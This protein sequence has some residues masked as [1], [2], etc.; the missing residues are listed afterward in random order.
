MRWNLRTRAIL[1]V[2]ALAVVF[3]GFSYR[4]IQLQHVEHEKYK[5]IAANTHLRKEPI[6][7]RRGAI[8]DVN[9]ELLAENIPVRHVVVDGSLVNN[10]AELV[11]LLSAELEINSAEIAAKITPERKYIII[12]REVPEEVVRRIRTVA[13]EKNLK[14]LVFEPSS[15]RIYPN[16][17]MLAHVISFMNQERQGV[18]GV[19]LTMNRFLNGVNGY[20]YIERDRTGRELVPYRGL[21]K[22]AED[23]LNVHLTVDL[24]LQN[25]VEKHLDEAFEKYKPRSAVVI[26]VRPD[27]GE[28]VSMAS[29]PTFNPNQLGGTN[30]EQMKNR[31]IIDMVEPGS[32]FK[33]VVTSAGLNESTVRPETMIFC[34]NG[35]Y[36]YGGKIL[37]DHRGYGFLSVHDVLVKSSNIGSA[38]IAMQLGDTRYYEYIRRFGFGERSGVDLPGEIPGLLHPPSRWSQLSITR[39]P[40]GHEICATPL[41][42]VMAM[43]AVA[44]GG[45]L[46]MP[47]ILKRLTDSRGK[48]VNEFEPVTIRQVITPETAQLV[49]EALEGVVNPGGTATMAAVPGYRVAG[50]TGTAQRVDPKGGY[51]PG[52]YV[53]SFLGYFPAEKPELCGLVILDDCSTPQGGN[54]GG[55]IA[56][57]IFSAIAADAIRY[58]NFEPHREPGEESGARV[59]LTQPAVTTR[60]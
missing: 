27:T 32:T 51:T 17:E 19:E 14:G 10:L 40:M 31:A 46:M 26:F 52:K 3:T 18:Q 56:A 45:R 50:K 38:K 55:L 41:Q 60:P 44:N 5:A 33:I 35:R 48:L 36:N 20:R 58:F 34:E 9:H 13:I 59:A 12:K 16:N 39:I 1:V 6:I 53:V 11:S 43:S 23:G 7:S 22:D 42:L 57:P 30:D 29:R 21:E 37:R 2:I 25:I 47:Q 54:Y 8:Y 24:G 28:I 49:S 15:I 4:L